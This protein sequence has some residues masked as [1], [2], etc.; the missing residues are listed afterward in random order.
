MVVLGA[1]YAKAAA[2]V[3]TCLLDFI[4]AHTPHRTAPL[5]WPE[6]TSNVPSMAAAGNRDA[7]TMIVVD[8]L[9]AAHGP[10]AACDHWCVNVALAQDAY[11]RGDNHQVVRHAFDAYG[12]P[13]QAGR[14]IRTIACESG[15]NPR[16]QS[17]YSGWG[18]QDP[19][20]WG[21]RSSDAGFAGWSI[22]DPVAQSFTMAHMIAS[23]YGWGH[24]PVCGR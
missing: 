13:H 21:Q 7:R 16:A 17:Y 20:T 4:G 1:V 19:A 24:W 18:Q 9:M 10:D 8:R 5:T 12:I 23:G 14:G 2:A 22:Y 6:T 11:W 3:I 15:F